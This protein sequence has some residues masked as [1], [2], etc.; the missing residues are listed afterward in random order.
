MKRTIILAAVLLLLTGTIYAAF[1]YPASGIR[2]NSTRMM[3]ANGD[4]ANWM[5]EV[6]DYLDGT[7]YA[8][9]A[10][11]A[12]VYW[13]KTDTLPSTATEGAMYWDDSEN[14]LKAHNGSTWITLGSGT[15]TGG[16]ISS[17][18][19][20]AD[21]VDVLS[22]TTTAESTG[23]QG[24]ADAGARKDAFRVTNGATVAVVVGASD[25]SFELAST[26]LDISSAGAISNATTIAMGGA[27]SGATTG[28][29][30]GAVTAGGG[31]ILESAG[32]INNSTDS[33]FK[34]TDDSEDLSLD[35]TYA[36]NKAGF[37]SSTGLNAFDF[38]DVDDVNGVGNITFDSA[39]ATITTATN[40]AA[41][42]LTI[43]ITGATDSSVKIVSSGTGSD[44]ISM[45]TSAGGLDITVA[46][47]AA[48]EDLDM[49]ANTSINLTANE[50][51]VDDAIVI[52]TGG[53]GSGMQI[54]SLADIDITTTG[55]AGEDITVTNTG[56]SLN[57]RANEN[58]AAAIVIDTAGGG[59]TSEAINILNDQGTAADSIDFDSTA[60][61]MDTDV[62]GVYTVD[63][64][65]DITFTLTSGAGGEDFSILQNGANDSSIL[66][67]AQGTGADA[68]GLTAAAGTIKI[69][70]D[71]LDLDSTADLNV[72]V[73]SSTA[74]EDMLLTQVGGND[75]SITLEA[76]GT[77]AD[78]IG[79]NASG[80][81]GGISADTD[82]G[83]ISIVADG[84]AN[85]DISL[86][87]ED[88]ITILAADDISINGNSAGSIIN[89]GTNND[90]D[91]INIATDNSVADTINI[92]SALDT[93]NL[94]AGSVVRTSQQYVQSIAYAKLGSTGAGWV[95]GA[96]DDVSLAT[97][98]QSQTAE[99]MVIPITIPLKV[100]WTITAF[101][102]NGQIDSAGGAVTLD[103]DLRKH[104]EATAG[105]A[106]ASIGAI[107]QIAKT[108]DYK[109][110]DA[111]SSLA[112]VVA[113]D[114][115]YYILV[116]GTTAATTDIEI[117]SVTVT[118]SEL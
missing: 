116:T 7:S 35:L 60:G 86:D 90:G 12:D 29:F 105:Y 6:E 61:G 51:G 91:V 103:A 85:G 71:V 79:L 41:D 72:T 98:P 14:I 108:A 64:G 97:L 46:G 65:D 87:A 109:I 15:F 99:K 57:L 100:G 84:A 113:A 88:D 24:Y 36:S 80:T 70:G 83:A 21:G 26:G 47:A 18:I 43:S 5:N 39:A 114:E 106:D 53:A 56:G 112:E 8:D 9:G 111:K 34:F 96:A 45:T 78:A 75:S 77:G 92:G 95:I 110:T 27:L 38:G 68:I 42:D 89:I 118:V 33:E 32:T 48:S 3:G 81:G 59:G 107:T 50:A 69:A 4:L 54:T 82:D 16:A 22:S 101:S 73:T 37:K 117:A 44:A 115:S 1:T 63:A 19:T 66:L 30:S 104:T 76:A 40:A 62:A 20:M 23:I 52:A 2:W 25:V 13:Q 17:D 93:I 31:L 58:D 67:T 94:N 102:L 74:G 11:L 49:V 10:K 28:A 55:A